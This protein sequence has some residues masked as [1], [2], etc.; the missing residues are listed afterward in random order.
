MPS[1]YGLE[2]NSGGAPTTTKKPLTFARKIKGLNVGIW[3]ER[4]DLNLRPLHPQCSALPNCATLRLWS[5]V[6]GALGLS[7]TGMGIIP[8]FCDFATV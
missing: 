2:K 8:D 7:V 4:Q 1:Y 6:A 5:T 3:S